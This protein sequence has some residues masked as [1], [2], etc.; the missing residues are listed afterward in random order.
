MKIL[1]IGGNRFV[2]KLV[3]KQL[4]KLDNISV[5]LIN[6]SGTGPNNCVLIKCDRNTKEFKRQLKIIAPDIVIDMCLYNLT[7]YH[8]LEPLLKQLNLKKYIFISSIASKFKSFGDYGEQKGLL[9]CLI[10]K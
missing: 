10:K 4:S 3:A 5:T 7:Q 9:E 2:G 6:R 1:I 8:S